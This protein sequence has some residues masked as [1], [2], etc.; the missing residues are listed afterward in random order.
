MSIWP[1]GE[2]LRGAWDEGMG[3]GTASAEVYAVRTCM[4]AGI[5]QRR[6]KGRKVIQLCNGGEKGRYKDHTLT[7]LSIKIK[8][9]IFRI[10]YRFLFQDGAPSASA[11]H[12]LE[13]LVRVLKKGA[14]LPRCCGRARGVVSISR[15]GTQGY[16]RHSPRLLS[17]PQEY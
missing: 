14:W 15:N 6:D 13:N 4:D 10:A 8:R 16:F 9:H 1:G 3:G 17:V 7:L 5:G 11:V 2:E 12:Y